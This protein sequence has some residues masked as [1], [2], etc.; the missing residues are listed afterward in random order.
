MTLKPAMCGHRAK[1]ASKMT[2]NMV[3]SNRILLS[4]VSD[5][6]DLCFSNR[7]SVLKESEVDAESS[8]TQIIFLAFSKQSC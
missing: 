2:C 6:L 7:F 5:H 4:F 8:P 1:P 3:F